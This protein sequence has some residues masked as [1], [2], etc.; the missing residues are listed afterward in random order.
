MSTM[1]CSH[2]SH[3]KV[4]ARTQNGIL[5]LQPYCNRCGTLKNVSSDI[6]KDFGYF[7]IALSKLRKILK[8]RGYNVSDAQIR[9]ITKELSNLEDFNDTWWITFS[10]QKE[11]FVQVVQKYIKVSKGLIESVI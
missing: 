7:V 4:W 5:K 2:E 1:P 10:K 3:R 8:K 6:G 11:I 9:L